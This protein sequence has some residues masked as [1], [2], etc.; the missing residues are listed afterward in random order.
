MYA[1]R[2][3]L[4]MQKVLVVVVVVG[5]GAAFTL[6]SLVSELKREMLLLLLL[7]FSPHSAAI[8]FHFGRFEYH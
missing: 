3:V 6:L 2:C 4:Y 7:Q 8:Q 1:A 5:T